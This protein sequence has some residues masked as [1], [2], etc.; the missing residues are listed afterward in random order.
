M[1]REIV[2]NRRQEAFKEHVSGSIT[3]LFAGDLVKRSADS[4]YPFIVN[5]NFYYLTQCD[6]DGLIYVQ[7]RNALGNKEI[8]FIKDHNPVLEK[9]VGKSLT[10]DEAIHKSGVFMI[11]P[12]SQFESFFARTLSRNDIQT[13]YID[14]ERDQLTHRNSEAEHFVHRIQRLYP[15][16]HILNINQKLNKMRTIKSDAEVELIKE[17]IDVTRLGIEALVSKLKPGR[18][19]YQAVA[20]FKYELNLK[21]CDVSFDTIAASGK[22]ATVL[23]YVS[24]HKEMKDGDLLLLDCGAAFKHYCGDI[25][26]TFPVNGKFT[27]RQREAYEIV[28]EAQNEVIKAIKPGVTLIQLNEVVRNVYKERC[29]Q[30]KMIDAPEH[31]DE[32][33]Y[34]S[35]SHSLGL[36]THDVGMFEGAVLEPGMVITVE[37]GL[38]LEHEGIGIRIEDDVLVT[39]TGCENLS[40]SIL[41]TVEEIEAFMNL[42]K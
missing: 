7:L 35:V 28:L 37:P 24:N 5:R 13:L 6:E 10:K 27:D 8:L 9:W 14:S 39:E 18:F 3:V 36:D 16:L 23:H 40:S 25:S 11:Q 2:I 17:A 1:K 4:T 15:G 26:R 33:Y 19:E 32:V 42:S 30:A 12:L 38:Y 22:D 20:D 31:V 34:H 21:D 41:K 29:V